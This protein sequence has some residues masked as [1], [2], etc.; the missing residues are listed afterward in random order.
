MLTFVKVNQQA[1]KV[2]PRHADAK[3]GR[4]SNLGGKIGLLLPHP[5]KLGFFFFPLSAH[6]PEKGHVSRVTR[7]TGLGHH[8]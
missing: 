7:V 6:E 5:A 8:Y 3:L 2:S 1:R 4:F